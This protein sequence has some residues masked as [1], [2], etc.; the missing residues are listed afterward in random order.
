M[1]R[2]VC[3]AFQAS[4]GGGVVEQSFNKNRMKTLSDETILKPKFI[5]WSHNT[6]SVCTRLLAS[7]TIGNL[8][9]TGCSSC[10]NVPAKAIHS[11]G[12]KCEG[13]RCADVHVPA[14]QLVVLN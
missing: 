11:C 5:R 10:L 6:R 1:T 9:L 3:A 14:A 7:A 4:S 13:R 12:V 2:S 8:S